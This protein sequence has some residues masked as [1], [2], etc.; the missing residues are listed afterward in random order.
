MNINIEEDCMSS[1][2]A[3][4]SPSSLLQMVLFE[5]KLCT[6]RPRNHRCPVVSDWGKEDGQAEE[7][8]LI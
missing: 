6:P 1:L 5:Y 2:D 8:Q 7:K 3:Y 4:M